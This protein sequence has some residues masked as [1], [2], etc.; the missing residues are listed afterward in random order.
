MSASPVGDMVL[1]IV[2]QA[3]LGSGGELAAQAAVD[4]KLNWNDIIIEGLAEF[5]TAP[6]EVV[7]MGRD[8][9]KTTS[10]AKR[11]G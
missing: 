11:S 7:A 2:T 10:A 6:V 5:T 1:Q 3:A 9:L 8:W 4:G